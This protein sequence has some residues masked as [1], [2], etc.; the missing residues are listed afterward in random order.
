MS[1]MM[2]SETFAIKIASWLTGKFQKYFSCLRECSKS[3]SSLNA[4]PNSCEKTGNRDRDTSAWRTSSS[5]RTSC[6]CSSASFSVETMSFIA[7]SAARIEVV[8]V[9]VLIVSSS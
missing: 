4:E 1:V 9:T 6:S 5:Q 8:T 2:R 3:K 7:L